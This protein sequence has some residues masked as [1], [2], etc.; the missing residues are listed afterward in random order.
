MESEFGVK[1]MLYTFASDV[2][3]DGDTVKGVSVVNKSGTT[4]I[5]AD[6]IID[7]SGDGDIAYKSG[8]EHIK[9]KLE[10]DYCGA[11]IPDEFVVGYGLDYSE[12]YRNL[13]YVGIL[14][15]EVYEK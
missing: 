11:V 7:A 10:V 13:P 2:I 9:G 4:D 12:K 3:M 15:R 1:I 6:I 8:A 5:Y 14:K